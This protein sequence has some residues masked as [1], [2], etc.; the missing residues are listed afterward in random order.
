MLLNQEQERA[1]LLVVTHLVTT[2]VNPGDPPPQQLGFVSG[3]AGTGKSMVINAIR[4]AFNRLK[5]TKRL[6]LT[7]YCGKAAVLIGGCTLHSLAGIGLNT[8]NSDNTKATAKFT[9]SEGCQSQLRH[10]EYII[11]DE[12]STVGASLFAT[13]SAKLNAVKRSATSVP[14]GGCNVICFGDFSQLPPCNRD[15]LCRSPTILL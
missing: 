8:T 1:Y 14:F 7:A 9:V 12:I 11:I 6:A 5:V 10:V 13:V 3:K 4:F 2:L 15:S